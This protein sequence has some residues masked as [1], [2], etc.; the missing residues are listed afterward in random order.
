MCDQA[1]KGW[2]DSAGR[3]RRA[4]LL[5]SM[6]LWGP[7]AGADVQVN[8]TTP[9]DLIQGQNEVD[10]AVDPGNSSRLVCA[11]ID[12]P[13]A[14]LGVSYSGNGGVTWTDTQVRSGCDGIDNDADFF[15][16]EEL[17]NGLDDDLPLDG[18]VDEDL[19][20]SLNHIDP[21]VVADASGNF[22]S[23]G[24][25]YDT[26]ATSFAGSSYVTVHRSTT[27]GSSWT[28]LP[29]PES[30]VY[31]PGG[32]FAP[33]LDK[34][35]LTVDRTTSPFRDR[36]YAAWQRDTPFALTDTHVRVSSWD[37][38]PPPPAQPAWTTPV[39]VDD[40]PPFQCDRFDS[41]ADG[42]IDEELCNG[43]DD[44]QDGRIDEDL[45]CSCAEAPYS[46]VAA[47]GS[48]WTVWRRRAAF[49]GQPSQF[50]VDVSFDGGATFGPDRPGLTFQE[51][52][53]TP[54]N[55]YY[56]V[57]SFPMLKVHPFNPL[58]LFVVYAEDPPGADPADVMFAFSPNGGM[59]WLP[60]V[61][62]NDD[63]TNAAQYMASL[64]VKGTAGSAIV[65][66]AW[67]DDRNSIGCDY[68]D[69]DGDLFADEERLNGI[70]DDNDFLIDEDV[71]ELRLDVYWAR[72]VNQGSWSNF[73]SN[74]RIS[75]V[76]FVHPT[77]NFL[78]DYLGITSDLQNDFVVWGDTRTNAQSDI[79][80]D[81][82]PDIDSDGDGVLDLNDC[83]ASDPN[84]W[85]QVVEVQTVAIDKVAATT[86]ATISWTSQDGSAGP[87]TR[88][89]LVGGLLSDLRSVGDYRNSV[90]VANDEPDTPYTD[91]QG[92]PP[93]GDGHY[94]L[95]RAQGCGSSSYGDGSLVPDPRD[96]LEDG[97]SSLPDPDPCP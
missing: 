44:D 32:L 91:A 65:D 76:S 41:D 34:T 25:A 83:V 1:E 86:D 60:P 33:F 11:Y 7:S 46:D 90:C 75:D 37:P 85:S 50:I 53:S 28:E 42:R 14:S 68:V 29:N 39:Q 57:G 48:V 8:G 9:A 78:G 6:A 24:V 77:S 2:S 93:T 18:R 55:H 43:L 36:V 64:T 52:G 81:L 59:S 96:G 19:C 92:N 38:N 16:D 67:M 71:C 54:L 10:I 35:W 26:N 84:L 40:V 87:A 17:C 4:L 73:S 88:Y 70:D 79:Y 21:S 22:Y 49:C 80:F 69:D 61:R 56:R 20:C 13:T 45:C 15:T 72:S 23:I 74:V 62:V 30:S 66:I 89:D 3:F 5:T 58:M 31:V 47:D 63:L 82:Q 12:A 95:V 27:G 94:V 51:I 97:F